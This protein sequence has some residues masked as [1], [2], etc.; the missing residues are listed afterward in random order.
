MTESGDKEIKT[1][2]RELRE[3]EEGRVPSFDMVLNS[4]AR[5]VPRRPLART[6]LACAA[7]GVGALC[8][9]FGV[10][11]ATTGGRSLEP[12]SRLSQWRSPTASLLR[13]P[14]D[15]FLRRDPQFDLFPALRPLSEPV[16]G[17]PDQGEE[18][19]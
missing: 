7:G 8:I 17:R 15:E 13:S 11:V 14:S 6:L 16:D 5:V 1:L 10:W 9:L 19:R 12:I 3:W 4:A 18:K 2:F